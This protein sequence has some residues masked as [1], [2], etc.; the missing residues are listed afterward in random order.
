VTSSPA[1]TAGDEARALAAMRAAADE[2]VDGITRAA[3]RYLVESVDRIVAAWGR[4]DAGAREQIAGAIRSEATT[5]TA[6]LA[7]ELRAFFDT[8]PDAQ[9]ATPLQIVRRLADRPT[10]L[11]RGAGIPPIERDEHEERINPDDDYGLAPRNLS[12]LPEPGLAPALMAWGAAKAV[13]IRSRHGRAR[14]GPRADE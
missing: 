13:V 5:I 10:Q 12:D 4:L 7:D 3:P 6:A 11:L 9:R 2:I 1:D 8:D 14:P